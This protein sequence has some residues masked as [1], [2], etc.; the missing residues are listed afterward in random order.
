MRKFAMAAAAAAGVAAI[1]IGAA[2]LSD[3]IPIEQFAA[4]PFIESPRLSPDG[5]KVAA[6]VAINGKQ[7][8]VVNSLFGKGA[9]KALPPG[10]LDIN[11][12]RWVNDDWLVV[13]LG[14]QDKIYEEE[15]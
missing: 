14:D 8:L 6:K 13:G 1:P 12:W 15:V 3:T 11:W 5:T 4:L 9:Q 10:K 2:P 7:S